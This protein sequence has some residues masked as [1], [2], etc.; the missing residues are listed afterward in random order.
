M[1]VSSDNIFR[2]SDALEGDAP[3]EVTFKER[4]YYL[5]FGK[6]GYYRNLTT[7]FLAQM[8]LFER[9]PLDFKG[10]LDGQKIKIAAFIRAAE[11]LQSKL[12][13]YPAT[14]KELS[15]LLQRVIALKYRAEGV[16]GGSDKKLE[17][18]A[19][20]PMILL[21]SDWKK[22]RPYYVEE[23]KHLSAGDKEV[24]NEICR[25]P[26][27]AS[28]VMQNS[29]LREELFDWSIK[30]NNQVEIFVEFPSVTERIRSVLLSNRVGRFA[31]KI[32]NLEKTDQKT[33]TMRFQVECLS[34]RVSILDESQVLEF[35]GGG[36]WSIRQVF[37]EHFAKK[38]DKIGDFEVFGGDRTKEEDTGILCWNA[39]E[40]GYYSPSIKDYVRIDLDAPQWWN[41]LP[42]FEI[43]E[44]EELQKRTGLKIENKPW[45]VAMASASR[46]N[47]NLD[48]DK[49]H[50]Y[51]GVAIR[52]ED[53]RYR[54]LDFGKYPVQFP[55]TLVE[56]IFFLTDT[57][58]S[59]LEHP[60]TNNFYSERQKAVH[61]KEL[62]EKKGEKLMGLIAEDLKKARKGD[63]IFQFGWDNC[64]YW[65]QDLFSKIFENTGNLYRMSLYK[66]EISQKV[67]KS[68]V[69]FG[70]CLPKRLQSVWMTFLLYVLG[71]NRGKLVGGVKKSFSD[72]PFVHGEE[73]HQL[74][75]PS[76]LHKQIEEKRVSGI[77]YGG[78]FIR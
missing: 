71:Y 54:V 42:V 10:N 72:T 55:V 31:G 52:Q 6:S 16:N 65:P 41:Q 21:L 67:L 19:C 58:I 20:E 56:K 37:E 73:P 34:R 69:W 36:K 15:T 22:T 28:L 49:C 30:E 33:V 60:E 62:D 47:P 35:R 29:S 24:V 32:M 59:K 68:V 66:T 18:T 43:V 64:A 40:L 45:G 23:Q 7:L 25:Y 48:I 75:C 76:Y 2:F 9:R 5:L 63:I 57:I 14:E 51:L 3:A 4:I 44:I 12:A 77:L 38:N 13:K 70:G 53:G 46:E 50:G 11:L 8:D 1:Q 61:A 17:A 78:H 27:F 74:F 26:D 39:H